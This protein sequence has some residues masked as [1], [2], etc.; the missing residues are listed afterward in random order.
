VDWF[1]GGSWQNT[2]YQE[3]VDRTTCRTTD[4]LEALTGSTAIEFSEECLR[5]LR[6]E[7]EIDD[8]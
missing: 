6:F 2:I 4:G 8:D 5:Q 3:L 1:E 7:D